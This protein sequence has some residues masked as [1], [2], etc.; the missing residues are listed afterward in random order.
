MASVGS[1]FESFPVEAGAAAGAGLDAGAA[2]AGADAAG[3]DVAAG[4]VL[5]AALPDLL[6]PPW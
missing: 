5:G 6:T 1:V 4:A 3:A 2:G